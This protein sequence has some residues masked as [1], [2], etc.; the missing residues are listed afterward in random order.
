MT[1]RCSDFEELTSFKEVGKKPGTFYAQSS[2]T[3]KLVLDA[4]S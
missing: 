2:G 3:P 1:V 4:K